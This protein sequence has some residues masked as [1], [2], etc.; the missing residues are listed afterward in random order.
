MSFL[1]SRSSADGLAGA[2][3]FAPDWANAEFEAVGATPADAEKEMI[4]NKAGRMNAGTVFMGGARLFWVREKLRDRR[5]PI[6]KLP[7]RIRIFPGSVK[8]SR[9]A[10]GAHKKTRQG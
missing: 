10:E 7:A 1:S 9:N 4:V 2:V 5:L 3:I 8:P 6:L